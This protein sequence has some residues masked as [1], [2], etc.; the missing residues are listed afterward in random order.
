MQMALVCKKTE[1]TSEAK[2]IWFSFG[3]ISTLCISKQT[4]AM[5]SMIPVSMTSPPSSPTTYSSSTSSTP[6]TS[7]PTCTR[8][9]LLIPWPSP[10]RTRPQPLHRTSI[11][12][13]NTRSIETLRFLT[14]IFLTFLLLFLLFLL[15][16]STATFRCS[17]CRGSNGRR[18]FSLC[19]RVSWPFW[20]C[21]CCWGS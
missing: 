6:H 8:L 4:L 10:S 16:P 7:P 17:A 19:S 12:I 20:S 13:S 9:T 15:R 5:N 2:E 21:Y 1:D 11:R 14:L 18:S 3:D